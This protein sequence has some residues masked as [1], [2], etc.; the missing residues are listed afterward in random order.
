MNLFNRYCRAKS[1]N[2]LIK[3][4]NFHPLS[5]SLSYRVC[6]WLFCTFAK[7]ATLFLLA[8]NK[9]H[10]HFTWIFLYF[11]IFWMKNLTKDTVKWTGTR[12][13]YIE[14]NLHQIS[15]FVCAKLMSFTHQNP[16]IP[17]PHTISLQNN[18]LL[19]HLPGREY[20][21]IRIFYIYIKLLEW[22]ESGF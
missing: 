4:L 8:N 6:V 16:I 7:P 19:S 11:F 5:R 17:T 20:W 15:L 14:I 3:N 22:V 12:R 2:L 21:K 13:I 1:R 18:H 9:N 10:P